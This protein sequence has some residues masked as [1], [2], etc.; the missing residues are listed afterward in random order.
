MTP[1][2]RFLSSVVAGAVLVSFAGGSE[3]PCG[4]LIWCSTAQIMNETTCCVSCSVSWCQWYPNSGNC[5]VG[6][7]VGSVQYEC[8][9]AV[10]DE[11]GPCARVVGLCSGTG[12]AAMTCLFECD[13]EGGGEG[14]A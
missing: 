4:G 9:R 13:P 7:S 5:A 14:G 6:Q 11:T 10:H 1:A 2:S 8:V 12:A 3:T